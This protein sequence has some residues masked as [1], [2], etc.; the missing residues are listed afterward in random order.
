MKHKGIIYNGIVLLLGAMLF[1]GSG[2]TSPSDNVS[3]VMPTQQT[4]LIV[5]AITSSAGGKYSPRNIVAIWIEDNAGKFV[6]SLTV[7]SGNHIYN[8]SNWTKSAAQN[9]VDAISTATR[10]GYGTIYGV[11]NG[12]NVNKTAVPNGIYKLCMELNDGSSS[13]Y[14]S[15][16]FTVA[17]TTET[18]TVPNAG[19]FSTITSTWKPL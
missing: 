5:S 13:N 17:A 3:E 11:W 1:I 12:T 9:R 19:N 4:G 8:L 6:K 16:T 7:Y 15:F 10:T 18:K 2:C 14:T